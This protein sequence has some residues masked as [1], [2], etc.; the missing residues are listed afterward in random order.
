MAS[1]AS[2]ATR[3]GGARR[4][5]RPQAAFPPER[6]LQMGALRMGALRMGAL[7]MQV[8]RRPARTQAPAISEPP[9]LPERIGGP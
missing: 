1:P 2:V 4:Q 6:V 5:G 3:A 9:R 8:L 7:R